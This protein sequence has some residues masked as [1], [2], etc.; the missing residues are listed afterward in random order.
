MEKYIETTMKNLE[1]NGMKP[2]YCETKEEALEIVKSLINKGESV[3]NGGSETLKEC[4]VFEV[5]KSGDY[6]FIDRTGLT[7]EA[8][9]DAYVRAFGC[10]TYFCSSNAVTERGELYNVDGNSNRVACIVYGP[11]QVVMLVGKNKIVP[12]IDAAIKRVKEKAAPPNCVRLSLAN[13]CA[14]TGKCVSL[15]LD[16]PYMCD[17]CALDSRICCS[18]VVSAKQRHKDRIKV[19]IINEDLGY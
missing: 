14:K 6:D 1:K 4:G 2:Y 15:N 7:G 19:I 9:R 17:G 16:D 8:V 10:D 18:Y 3:S 11:R 13:P 5:L 12:D